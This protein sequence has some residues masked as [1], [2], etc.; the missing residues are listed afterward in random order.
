MLTIVIAILF[1]A[2][3]GSL[4]SDAENST[5]IK[6][7]Y[8]DYSNTEF[9]KEVI[10]N[11]HKN[12]LLNPIETTFEKGT[13]KI[14]KGEIEAL[15]VI[16]AE[17]EEMVYEGDFD[18]LIELYY[19]SNNYLSPIIGDV[20]VGEMLEEISIITAINYLEEV[21]GDKTNKEAILKSAYDYGQ[22]LAKDRKKDYYVNIEFFSFSEDMKLA[23]ENI[24]NQ[25]IYHQ[26]ILGIILSFL[27]FFVL[28][29][30]TS[31]VKDEENTLIQKI[32]ISKT[33]KGVIIMGDYLSIVISSTSIALLFSAISA[34]FSKSFVRTLYFN[35]I[36]LILFIGSFSA[37]IIMLTKLFR[38]VSSFVVMGAALILIIG[39]ISGCFFNIDLSLPI[40]KSIAF[41]TPSY[42]ALNRLMGVIVNESL[43][44]IGGY[45]IYINISIVIFL[46]LS[47]F[48]WSNKRNYFT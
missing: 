44:N 8:V 25:L 10:R 16:K 7:G 43:I 34:Y 5:K 21:I 33:P 13:K 26:M 12:E 28:F 24:N 46:L 15:F 27:C 6:I 42:Q 47:A 36:I 20:F 19:L 32:V 45:I 48:I 23:N 4:Y 39:I 11:L 40:I 30:A 9:S 29:A 1:A 31:I 17:A 2:L 38:N 3:I 14:K 18:E 41:F 22:E 35:S 37:L